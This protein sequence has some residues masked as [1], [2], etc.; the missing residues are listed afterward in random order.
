MLARNVSESL[1]FL[2]RVDAGKADP[3]LRVVAFQYC[4]SVTVR[5]TDY[6]TLE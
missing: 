6:A 5:A 3:V 1:T 2:R 4:D